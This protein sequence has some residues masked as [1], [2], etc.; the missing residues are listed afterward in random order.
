MSVVPVGF[1]NDSTSFF[2]TNAT[3]FQSALGAATLADN[4]NP[5]PVVLPFIQ[6]NVQYEVAYQ[7]SLASDNA[8]P[9]PSSTLGFAVGDV[10]GTYFN[11]PQAFL[12]VVE[13]VLGVN[14]IVF[15]GSQIYTAVTDGSLNVNLYLNRDMS[16]TNV[17]T[18]QVATWIKSV[19]QNLPF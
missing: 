18:A 15:Q 12:S 19:G 11:A 16:D 1:A 2:G 9:A 5:I 14:P 3:Y 13:P 8:T 17:Y 10:S 4:N 7:V 6:S